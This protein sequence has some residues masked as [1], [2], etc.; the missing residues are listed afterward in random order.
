MAK[1]LPI[2]FHADARIEADAS[3]DYYLQRNA[4]AAEAFYRELEN[5][6][7]QIQVGRERWPKYLY[8]TRRYLLKRFPFV[9][10]YRLKESRIEIMAVAHGRRRPG[11]W[12]T[13][14]A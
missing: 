1:L 6:L 12:S 11:Y 14:L 7:R 9:I 5:A 3:F 8:G 13:R 10:V 2:E 4:R